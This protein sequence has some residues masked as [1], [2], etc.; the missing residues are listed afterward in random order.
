[1]E[2]FN[3]LLVIFI[4]IHILVVVVVVTFFNHN[5]VN[6]KLHLFWPLKIYEIKD[7]VSLNNVNNETDERIN[8]SK[9]ANTST[10]GH[11]LYCST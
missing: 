4:V 10:V 9:M 11:R 1:M 6:C 3:S 8:V 5:F 7:N 2:I